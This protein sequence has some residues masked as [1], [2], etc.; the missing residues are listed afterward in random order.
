MLNYMADEIT[1]ADHMKNDFISSISH[2]LRTP[3]TGIKGWAETM[4]DPEGLTE[5]EMKF[6]LK[7]IDEETERLISLV[8]SLLDFSRYQSDRM[9][10]SLSFVPFDELIEK[11]TFELL[12]KGRKKEYPSD[13]G[14]H[15]SCHRSRLG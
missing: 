9:I 8:E 13:H 4:R 1:K 14:N 5:E 15:S 3:L 11:V 10:L 12:K 7:I 6:G 2:E